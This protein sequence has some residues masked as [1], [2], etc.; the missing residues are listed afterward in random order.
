MLKDIE[1]I[2]LEMNPPFNDPNFERFGS[3]DGIIITE[4]KQEGSNADE[5]SSAEKK[6]MGY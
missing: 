3:P 6:V 5:K 1:K 2:E 4:P